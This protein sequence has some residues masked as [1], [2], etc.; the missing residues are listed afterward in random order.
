VPSLDT[1]IELAACIE[2]TIVVFLVVDRSRDTVAEHAFC[3][4]GE[5]VG[6]I[7]RKESR[8]GRGVSIGAVVGVVMLGGWS[9]ELV[10]FIF[11]YRGVV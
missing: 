8:R 9:D 5:R 6:S 11:R 10:E 1:T 2:Y 4:G 3:E 7:G